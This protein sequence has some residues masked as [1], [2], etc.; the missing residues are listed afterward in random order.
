MVP[1][2]LVGQIV[3]GETVGSYR[4]ITQ[5]GAGAMGE[6][7]VAEHRH[8]KRKAAIKLLSLELVDRPDLIERFFLEARATSAIDHPGIVQIF[9]CEVDAKGRPYIVMECLSGET[10]AAVMERR[11]ALPP[12]LAALLG[13][14]VAEALA[15]AHQREIIHRD[16][17]PENIFVQAQPLNSIKLLDFGIAK[18]AGEFRAGRVHET[19]SGIL[20]GTPLYMSPEQCRDSGRVDFRTDLYSL[21]CV[22][23]AM[24]TGRPPFMHTSFGELVV[25]HLTE[26]PKDPRAVN[27]KLPSVPAVM[28][29]LVMRL[30]R[31]D[32]AE[33]PGSM[34]EVAHLLA[35]F[36]AQATTAGARAPAAP[37]AGPPTPT[38][39]PP[40]SAGAPHTTFRTAAA[41]LVP[42]EQSGAARHRRIVAVVIGV[43]LIAGAG[44]LV[45]NGIRPAHDPEPVVAP[46]P[47]GPDAAHSSPAIL[48]AAG[49]PRSVA[50]PA[51][52][53]A[54]R[55]K[56]RAT[57]RPGAARPVSDAAQTASAAPSWAGVWEGPWIDPGKQQRGRL[58]L[59]VET[60]GKVNGWMSNTGANKT[61]RLVGRMGS[62]GVLELSCQCPTGQEFTVRGGVHADGAGQ[63]TGQLALAA[64]AGVFGESQVTLKLVS[65]P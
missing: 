20:M 47:A 31:K 48:D 2:K 7:W 51:A 11:G 54:A 42:K 19:H 52:P 18:L 62:S 26:E 9:D 58:Y 37:A 49:A 22:L 29:E 5:L 17:K 63:L 38:G 12:V 23:Y 50:S 53:A 35:G 21:G 10:L 41:E 64:S 25:A 30:L 3:V 27:P 13:K 36:A 8:L 24:L 45:R 1:G 16:I 55:F 39:S 57:S 40:Q 32:P 6:V 56:Q 59:K 4:I 33:R 46:P 60:Q 65:P 15:A 44:A 28:A 43:V 14:G 61:F 34:I